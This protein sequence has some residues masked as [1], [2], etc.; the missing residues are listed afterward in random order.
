MLN[1]NAFDSVTEFRA[2]V[3]QDG[4]DHG[5]T[6]TFS[7]SDLVSSTIDDILNHSGIKGMHWGIRK[8]QDSSTQSTPGM[9]TKKKVA[10]G[11][12][13]AT[14]VIGTAF[15]IHMLKSKPNIPVTF[16]ENSRQKELAM[17]YLRNQH[18]EFWNQRVGLITNPR[19]T[20]LRMA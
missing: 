5:W 1:P 16:V 19:F 2:A 8:E 9:S 20:D 3:R 15:V 18:A 10:I 4:L 12:G 17:E 14:A 7:L 11:A 13:I 6:P